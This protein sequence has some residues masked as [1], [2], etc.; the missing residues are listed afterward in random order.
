[1]LV[2]GANGG[3]GMATSR[4]LAGQGAQVVMVCRS[5]ERGQTAQNQIEVE[6]G[7]KPDL[8]LADL[9]RPAEVRQ[10]A[11]QIKE[12]YQR[13][14]ALINIAGT[15]FKKRELTEDGLERTFALNHL[16]YFVLS[17]EL[18]DLLKQSA[19][20]RIVNVTS[21]IYK[22]GKIAFD[23]LQGEQKYSYFGAY[24]NSKL[25]NIL[26]TYELARRLSGSGVT[27]NCLNPGP[28][29]SVPSNATPAEKFFMTKLGWLFLMKKPE[30]AGRQV[31][32]LATSPEAEGVTGKYLDKNYK[33]TP[34]SQASYDEALAKKLWT[35]SE[36]LAGINK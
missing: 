26:F 21:S 16:G 1:M 7:N 18:L 17:L 32:Y 34:T 19:T 8:F 4:Q 29:S 20:S 35:V 9:S 27:V 30:V 23:N 12:Q 28:I 2:T 11:G 14:D 22:R 25:A 31:V 10:L 6:T 33:F 3:I 24:A 15:G 36:H 13:L 5:P